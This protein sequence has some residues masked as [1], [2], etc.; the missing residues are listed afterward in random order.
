MK[1]YSQY[2]VYPNIVF[3]YALKD[4]FE[5]HTIKGDNHE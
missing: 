3:N 4:V 1:K 5:T 2:G